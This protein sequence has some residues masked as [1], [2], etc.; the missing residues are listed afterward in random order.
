LKGYIRNDP[1]ISH[2]LRL[3]TLVA[4]GIFWILF[5]A[6]EKEYLVRKDSRQNHQRT[7]RGT[8]GRSVLLN[9]YTD[10]KHALALTALHG[11]FHTESLLNDLLFAYS[12]KK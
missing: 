4:S 2:F 1:R 12:S 11:F 5:F 8:M 3:R 10:L 9:F 6:V 7:P